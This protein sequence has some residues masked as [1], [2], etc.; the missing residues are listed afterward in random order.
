MYLVDAALYKLKSSA[1][2]GLCNKTSTHIVAL[3]FREKQ[4]F[5]HHSFFESLV[6]LF[7]ILLSQQLW[8]FSF[9][10]RYYV[11]RRPIIIAADPEMLEQIFI[12]EFSN[13]HSRPVCMRMIFLPAFNL[14]LFIALCRKYLS[15]SSW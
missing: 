8:P 5:K 6:F 13:F 9:L 1:A 4:L 12:K 11:G 2:P 3:V 10:F 14:S 7:Y 15:F